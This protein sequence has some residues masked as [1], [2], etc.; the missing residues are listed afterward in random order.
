[1]VGCV[2]G[3][4]PGCSP[5]GSRSSLSVDLA[6]KDGNSLTRWLRP[7]KRGATMPK[8]RTFG[9]AEGLEYGD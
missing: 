3:R 6:A 2:A 9:V 4:R 7:C 8:K 5:A 1:M